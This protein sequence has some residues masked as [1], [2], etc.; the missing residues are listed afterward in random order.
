MFRLCNI[1]RNIRCFSQQL[2]NLQLGTVWLIVL[3]SLAETTYPSVSVHLPQRNVCR[4]E[5]FCSHRYLCNPTFNARNTGSRSAPHSEPFPEH[6]GIHP[7][8]CP[9]EETYL[10]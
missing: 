8:S 9:E 1:S 3:Y 2:G 10:L 6:M 4:I 7:T 5:T